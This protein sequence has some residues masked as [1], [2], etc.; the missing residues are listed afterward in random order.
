MTSMKSGSSWNSIDICYHSKKRNQS[1]ESRTEMNGM[2]G[3]NKVELVHEN[4]INL[5]NVVDVLNERH[6]RITVH[7]MR[8]QFRSR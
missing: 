7:G 2:N 6:R 4:E 1:K 5:V 8:R 3:I